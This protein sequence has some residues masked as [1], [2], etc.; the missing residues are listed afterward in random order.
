MGPT[1]CGNRRDF[2]PLSINGERQALEAADALRDF[3]GTRVIA[4]PYTRT[5]QTG[6][7]IAMALRPPL[8]ARFRTSAVSAVQ[9]MAFSRFASA[10]DH[11]PNRC[12]SGSSDET[13]SPMCDASSRECGEC[14]NVDL[15]HGL[16]PHSKLE[17]C[18]IWA[19]APMER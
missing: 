19:I 16:L 5:L 1:F 13:C 8:S 9:C 14:A 3:R 18:W 11:H 4:S 12:D 6:A 15:S 7:I 17:Y 2:A 10:V